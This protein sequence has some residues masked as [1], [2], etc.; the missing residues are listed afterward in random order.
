MIYTL[1][2]ES[3]HQVFS[4]RLEI[5][6]Q[7][8]IRVKPIIFWLNKYKITYSHPQLEVS[9]KSNQYSPKKMKS[10]KLP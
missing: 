5:G 1:E 7:L 2:V 9:A 3:S 6:I 8:I 4:L 10:V